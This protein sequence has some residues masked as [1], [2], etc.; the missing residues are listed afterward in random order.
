MTSFSVIAPPGKI[1]VIAENGQFIKHITN[2]HLKDPWRVSVGRDG[3]L[4]VCDSG[5]KTIKVL[6]HD[7]MEL[8]QSFTAPDCGESPWFAVCHQEKFFVSYH[9]AD[10]VKVFSKEGVFLHNIGSEGSGDGQFNRPAGLAVDMFG[11]LIVWD[12]NF[13][14]QSVFYT[15]SVARSPCSPSFTITC[16][17]FSKSAIYSVSYPINY[18][19]AKYLCYNG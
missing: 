6:S 2:K 18:Y 16:L 7:G 19:L 1:A 8:L 5:D 15:Q 11:R 9:W 13:I 12:R 3:H 17:L 10:C 14:P 4:I